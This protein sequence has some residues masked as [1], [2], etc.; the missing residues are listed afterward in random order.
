MNE[1][2]PVFTP[3]EY[4][5]SYT[6]VWMGSHSVVSSR[7]ALSPFYVI[8]TTKVDQ[9]RKRE[10]IDQFAVLLQSKPTV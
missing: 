9:M 5:Y 8:A 7:F 3:R 1:Y 10:T 2:L 4:L 6:C